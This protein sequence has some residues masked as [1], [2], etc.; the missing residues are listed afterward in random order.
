MKKALFIL[1][2]ICGVAYSCGP[3]EYFNSVIKPLQMHGIVVKKYKTPPGCFGGIVLKGSDKTDTLKDI[4]YCVDSA[5]QIWNYV[6]PN[7]SLCKKGGSMVIDV[8][9]NGVKKSFDYPVC[10]Q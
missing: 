9:R 2:I 3:A 6:L 4:C 7:D 5:Q 1:T 10:I 8:Y